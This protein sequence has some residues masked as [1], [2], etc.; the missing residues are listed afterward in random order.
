MIKI[1]VY[2]YV[3]LVLNEAQNLCSSSPSST[4]HAKYVSHCALLT[5]PFRTH[6]PCDRIVKL[7]LHNNHFKFGI[8]VLFLIPI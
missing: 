3:F 2:K 6:M 5:E 4:R 8:N 7:K 1:K